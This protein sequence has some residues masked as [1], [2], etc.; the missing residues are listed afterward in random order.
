MLL[1]FRLR[2]ILLAVCALPGSLCA[3]NDNSAGLDWG[4]D[5]GTVSRFVAVHGRRSA[6]F[7]YSENG[8]E[9]WVYPLQ[10]LTGY[11]V[12]FRRP[13]AVAEING[14]TLLRRIIYSPEA[15]TRIYVGPD[16]I[17]REKIFVPLEQP[18]TLISYAVE[19]QQ[20]VDVVVR[21]TPV[22]D[23][24][25]PAALGGQEF[26][27]DAGLPGYQLAEGSHRYHAIVSSTNIVA[28]DEIHNANRPSGTALG[29]VI[30]P[31]AQRHAQVVIAPGGGTF[32]ADAL[33]RAARDHYQQLQDQALRIETPDPEVNRALQWSE[34][35]VDQAWVCNPDL[36]CGQ[37]GGYG[38]SRRGRRPQYAW[39]FAGDGLVSA[40]SLIAS[41]QYAATH[42]A[43]RR[44]RG[45]PLERV[46]G[47]KNATTGSAAILAREP[48]SET[49][50]AGLRLPFC[51]AFS[52]RNN[53]LPRWTNSPR[54]ISRPTGAAAAGRLRMRGTIP[55]PTP[56][57]ASGPSG[58]R[59]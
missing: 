58:Q 35:A 47:M 7:G 27:W 31:D 54:P 26:H 11:G 36:G 57:E 41:G 15:V 13:D 59:K 28:H 8:L 53:E 12:S 50:R 6:A 48:P 16:F 46:T 3:A 56:V 33:E 43:L 34:I 39:F 24:M 32:D 23:L 45:R 18:A 17:V 19:G 2:L 10:I 9:S 38:P 21:F 4:T 42:A 30:R 55:T 40:Q 20:P 22:L 29:L 44:V 37:V 5:S 14:K 1:F 49:V 51:R 25:W 52:R